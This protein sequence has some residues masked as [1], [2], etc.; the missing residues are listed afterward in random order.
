MVYRVSLCVET[1]SYVISCVIN[2]RNRTAKVLVLVQQYQ[3]SIGIGVA[4]LP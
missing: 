4:I 1:A 3:K 2:V